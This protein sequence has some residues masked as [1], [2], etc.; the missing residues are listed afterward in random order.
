[1]PACN[2]EVAAR[3]SHGWEGGI[4]AALFS[5]RESSTCSTSTTPAAS[6]ARAKAHLGALDFVT[7][8][9]RVVSVGSPGTGNAHLPSA[10]PSAPAR[11]GTG[12]V[13]DQLGEAGVEGAQRRAAHAKQTSAGAEVART[14]QRHQAVDTPRHQIAVRRLAVGAP[15]PAAEVPGRHVRV[16][17]ERLDVQRPCVVPVDPIASA[18]QRASGRYCAESGRPVRRGR[19]SHKATVAQAAAHH[20][21]A[22]GGCHGQDR[23]D[24][25]ARLRST[26][27]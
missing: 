6:T 19:T 10:G 11:P 18:V 26:S 25:G 13:H 27:R 8:K 17:C 4:R 22:N 7:A 20:C 1:L 5:V 15:E 3:K 14:Q 2:R 23:A 12:S 24:V 9:G 21:R 16:P